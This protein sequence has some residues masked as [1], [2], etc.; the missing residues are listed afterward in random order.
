MDYT[1]TS[2]RMFAIAGC[3]L[4]A[5]SL[6]SAA[7]ADRSE[8]RLSKQYGLGYLPLMVMQHDKLIEKDARALGLKGVKAEWVTFGGGG[9]A[10]DALLS[11]NVDIVGGGIGAFITLW[12][13]TSNN[14]HVKSPGVLAQF[15]MLL[16]TNDPK[17][18]S[19][20]DL[21]GNDKIAVPAVK[22]SP[23]AITLE[24]AAAHVWGDKNYAK[25]DDLTVNMKH[26][27]AMQALLAGKSVIDCDFTT[28]PFTYIELRNPK[29]H[30]LLNSFNVWGG[31]QS[32]TIVWATSKFVDNNPTLYNAFTTALAQATRFINDH[33]H[34]AAEIYVTMAHDKEGVAA[35][36]KM[37]SDPQLKFTQTPRHLGRFLS[38]KYRTGTLKTKPTSW[39]DLFFKNVWN[40]PGS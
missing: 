39:K 2:L 14:L 26:P 20:K 27:D 32:A 28:P 23:Q 3:A 31:P 36:Y 4:I 24:A 17:L 9:I 16:N 22:I 6:P 7:K 15:P 37:L 38:F 35:V 5:M 29:I 33:K 21:S 11:G 8:I 10:N 34:K 19:I 13:K 25:L 1:T 12:D 30:T 40:R 18:R